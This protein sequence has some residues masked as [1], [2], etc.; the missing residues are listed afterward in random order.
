MKAEFRSR[1]SNVKERS[2]L[3]TLAPLSTPFVLIVD[4][5]SHCNL[6]CRFCPTGHPDLIKSTGRFQGAMEMDTFKKV[7]DDLAEFPSP[8]KV[9]R[10]YKEGEP[11]MNKRLAEMIL[12]ARQNKRIRRI[13]TTTN[14]VLLTPANSEKIISAGI[15]QINISVNG[16]KNEQFQEIVKTKV[17]F[18]R[19]VRNIEYLFSIKGKCTIYIKA[20][21][22]NLSPDDQ[23][24]FIDTFGNIADRIFFEH[25]FPNWPGFSEESIPTDGKVALYGGEVK[26]QSVCP[27]IFYSTT[28]NSDGSVS[29]CIQDWARELVIGNIE[30]ESLHQIWN[31]N[32]ITEHRLQHLMGERKRNKT[33]G[34]CAVM[35]YSV[36]DNLDSNAQDI[37][38]RMLSGK[39]FNDSI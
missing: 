8:I 11:L 34:D 22:E 29:L 16:M 38:T 12:Y 33:C 39:Y 25:L 31:N 6:K 23:N 35:R 21:K 30:S 4:P 20:I 27:Y 17:D 2:D 19:Y 26:E 37:K 32:K 5:A 15:D 36:Y 7:I 14:G 18:D 1:L 10:L 24:R 9:L 3:A 13:D 28:I